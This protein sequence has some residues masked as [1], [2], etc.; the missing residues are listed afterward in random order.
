MTRLRTLLMIRHSVHARQ[1]DGLPGVHLEDHLVG[2]GQRDG[3]AREV[4][5]APLT[6]A[7]LFHTTG[8]P[9]TTPE[10]VL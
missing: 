6:C 2:H 5:L 9:R 10:V 7:H 4:G 3:A 8:V 1:L